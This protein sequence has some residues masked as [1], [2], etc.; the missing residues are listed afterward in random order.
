VRKRARLVEEAGLPLPERGAEAADLV[1]LV[2]GWPRAV[3][4][5]AVG[6]GVIMVPRSRPA[7]RMVEPL[8]RAA[9]LH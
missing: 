6:R 4:R 8:L 3:A 5:E 9:R 2:R 7:N 1:Q